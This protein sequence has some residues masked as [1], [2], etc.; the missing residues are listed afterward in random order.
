MQ[1][2]GDHPVRLRL[3]DHEHVGRLGPQPQLRARDPLGQDERVGRGDEDVALA[4]DDQGR[5]RDLAEPLVRVVRGDGRGLVD[6]GERLRGR[7]HAV[8]DV[9]GDPLRVLAAG[10]LAVRVRDGGPLR[11]PPAPSRPRARETS[12]P[13]TTAKACRPR[14]RRRRWRRGPGRRPGPDA[15]APAPARSGSPGRCRTR[16]RG[17]HSA[18]RAPRARPRPSARPSTAGTRGRCRPCRGCRTR[19]RGTSARARGS[20]TTSPRRS[21][22]ARGRGEPPAPDPRSSPS[23]ASRIR[24][25]RRASHSS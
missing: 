8:R 10:P 16:A 4:V 23:A 20:S 3:V 19:S 18:H 14:S 5:R 6:V 12:A 17:L 13:A 2:A 11:P 21:S 25:R 15:S 22:P 9:L 24:S 7:G 1:E